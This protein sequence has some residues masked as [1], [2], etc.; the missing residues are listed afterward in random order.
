MRDPRFSSGN[1]GREARRLGN[2]GVGSAGR[3][4]PRSVHTGVRASERERRARE[5]SNSEK[6]QKEAPP[7][8][9]DLH[10]ETTAVFYGKN[11]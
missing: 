9:T 3:L 11:Q 10:L 6:Q 7:S 8:A 4:L 2:V 5:A 1:R